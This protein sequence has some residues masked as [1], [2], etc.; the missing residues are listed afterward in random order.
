MRVFWPT[1][2]LGGEKAEL[3]VA[4]GT[5]GQGKGT[6]A[7]IHYKEIAAGIHPVAE[8]EFPNRDPAKGAI[9]IKLALPNR[10]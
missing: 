9:K 1:F 10:C 7:R 2:V 8:I 3:K 4:V 6:F 5:A